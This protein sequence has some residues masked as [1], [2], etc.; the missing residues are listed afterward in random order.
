MIRDDASWRADQQGKIIAEKSEHDAMEVDPPAKPPA[1]AS[2]A[3]AASEPAPPPP[4]ARTTFGEAPRP[5]PTPTRRPS[6]SSASSGSSR[7]STSSASVKQRSKKGP[8]DQPLGD[9]SGPYEPWVRGRT[10][11]RQ[12]ATKRA[13][14]SSRPRERAQLKPPPLEVYVVK[15]TQVV[16]GPRFDPEEIAAVFRPDSDVQTEATLLVIETRIGVQ[17]V[18]YRM[19]GAI[20]RVF[21]VFLDQGGIFK[22]RAPRNRQRGGKK[23]KAKAKA[24]AAAFRPAQDGPRPPAASPPRYSSARTSS[25][26]K[27]EGKGRGEKKARWSQHSWAD[28]A[29]APRQPLRSPT[30]PPAQVPKPKQGPSRRHWPAGGRAPESQELAQQ[31]PSNSRHKNLGPRSSSRSA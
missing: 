19:E 23:A 13:R 2:A 30:H 8:S 6:R 12:D 22:I 15:F 27:N 17:E 20:P 21:R 5:R 29:S 16:D 28:M 10:T 14:S 26:G 24:Q 4:Q 18:V 11:R 25:K 9:V 1:E 31:A 3:G 7:S